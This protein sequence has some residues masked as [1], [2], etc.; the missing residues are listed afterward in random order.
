M[1]INQAISAIVASWLLPWQGVTQYISSGDSKA[2][3]KKILATQMR[4]TCRL[5][6]SNEKQFLARHVSFK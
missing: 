2:P 5:E 1:I 6:G 3:L 4:I